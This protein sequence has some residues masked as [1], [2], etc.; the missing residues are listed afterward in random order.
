MN[1]KRIIEVKV[2]VTSF[3][4]LSQLCNKYGITPE[5]LLEGFIE[6]LTFGKKSHG[7]DERMLAIEYTERCYLIP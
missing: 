7:S 6:D 3:E 1:N 5:E 2:D 4:R